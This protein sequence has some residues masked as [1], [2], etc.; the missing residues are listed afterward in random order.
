MQLVELQGAL[1]LFAEVGYRPVAIST[2]EVEGAA[3]MA[4]YVRAEYPI[5]ADPDHVVAES[6]GV[7][8]LLNDDVAAPA[9]LLIGE[10]RVVHWR[11]VGEGIGDRPSISTILDAILEAEGPPGGE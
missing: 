6:F 4:Q 8:N 1:P 3:E 5:L 7:F 9:V 10:Y 2:D 11:Q